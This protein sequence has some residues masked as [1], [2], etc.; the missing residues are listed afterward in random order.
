MLKNKITIFVAGIS[1]DSTGDFFSALGKEV[2]RLPLAK[3]VRLQCD[4]MQ[5]LANALENDHED[6]NLR[7]VKAN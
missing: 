6:L 5:L 1:N 3:R 2:A 7:D 4:M